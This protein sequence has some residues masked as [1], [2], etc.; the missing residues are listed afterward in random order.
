[1]SISVVAFLTS[2]IFAFSLRP[3]I[4][5]KIGI[6]KRA[7]NSQ[8][9]L[10][11]STTKTSLGAKPI[12]VGDF[13]FQIPID[14]KRFN[15]DESAI[16]RNQF[17]KQSKEIYR[18]YYDAEDPTDT[19]K[20]MG[21]YISG[22]AGNFVLNTM[23]VP[24]HSD[25]MKDLQSQIEDKMKWGIKEGFI[26]KYLGE[27]AFNFEHVSGFYVKSI[28]PKGNLLVGG[29]LKHKEKDRPLFQLTLSCLKTWD[30]KRA[31]NILIDI[32]KSFDLIR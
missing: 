5:T 30:E 15:A 23:I 17:V 25:S 26:R 22:K 11:A 29:F 3:I 1:M 7:G 2:I 31:T 20:V 16:L 14:W 13:T 6:T 9:Q 19:V 21:F 32:L 27:S 8:I 4:D 10:V 28:D 18:D 24:P 12:T